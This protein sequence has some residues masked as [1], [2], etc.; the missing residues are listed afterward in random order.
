LKL[1]KDSAGALFQLLD[2]FLPRQRDIEGLIRL[3]GLLALQHRLWMRG[4]R[5]S[6]PLLHHVSQFVRDQFQA[7]GRSRTGGSR[8]QHDVRSHGVRLRVHGPGRS[9]R[10]RVRMNPNVVEIELE[11]RFEVAARGA[12][13]RLTGRVQDVVHD[14]RGRQCC[15]RRRAECRDSWGSGLSLQLPMSLVGLFGFACVAASAAGAFALQERV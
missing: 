15:G 7:G 13:Q 4:E 14:G 8:A 5:P 12:V 9:R 6:L 1:F 11:S 10:R 2:G 3:A